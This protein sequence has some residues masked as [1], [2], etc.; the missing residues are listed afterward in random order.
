[1]KLKLYLI[2]QSENEGFNTYDSAVVVAKNAED[3]SKIYPGGGELSNNK[4]R[5]W[6]KNSNWVIVKYLGEFDDDGQDEYSGDL[7]SQEGRVICASFN[8][9]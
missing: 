1:M 3:A 8:A 2:R 4:H 5:F 7:G 6:T 9:G